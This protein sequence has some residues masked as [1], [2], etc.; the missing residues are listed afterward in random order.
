MHVKRNPPMPW[1][2]SLVTRGPSNSRYE[3]LEKPPRWAPCTACMPQCSGHQHDWT[4][5][6]FFS[7]L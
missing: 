7:F 2:D 4:E 6:V 3:T 1:Q 5:S